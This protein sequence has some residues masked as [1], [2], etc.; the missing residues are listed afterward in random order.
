[1]S[2]SKH[3]SA[4]P[5]LYVI[6]ACMNTN[7]VVY[8]HKAI[9]SDL[10]CCLSKSQYNKHTLYTTE[11]L[12]CSWILHTGPKYTSLNM[13]FR[14][15]FSMTD[16]VPLHTCTKYRYQETWA[17]SIWDRDKMPPF[18]RQHFQCIFFND[19]IWILLKISLKVVHKSVT[20]NF[21]NIGSTLINVGTIASDDN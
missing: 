12:I 8:L 1:M 21:S 16:K 5:W 7:T 9:Y 10:L 15:F 19:N 17:C 11:S 6:Y 20:N 14:I 13:F 3:V 18:P 4:N 2:F